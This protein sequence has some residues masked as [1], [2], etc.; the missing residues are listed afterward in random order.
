MR[1]LK[2]AAAAVNQT[3]LDWQG[4][5][6]RLLAAITEAQAQGVS[7]LVTPELGVTGYGCEDAFLGFDVATRAEAVIATL[8]PHTRGICVVVGAP[9]AIESGLYNGAWVL[10]DGHLVAIVAKE[11]LAGDGV[12]YEPRWF[13]PWP[14]RA[15]RDVVRAGQSCPFGDL[16]VSLDDIRVGFEICEDAWI[17]VRRGLDFAALDVDVIVNP[18]AS[19]FAFAKHTT[20][21]QIVREGSRS[22]RAVYI[23]ANLLGNEAGRIVYDGGSL[24]AARGELVAQAPRFSFKPYHLTVA[25]VDVAL[26]R[27]E[28][29]RVSTLEALCPTDAR[30]VQVAFRLPEAEPGAKTNPGTAAWEHAPHLK[31]EEFAR[32]VALGLYDY[33]RKSGTQGYVVSLSGGADSAAVALLA[34]LAQRLAATELGTATSL[35]AF[36]HRADAL[37]QELLMCVYQASANSS[38]ATRDA[39][40]TVATALGAAFHAWEIQPLVDSY[41]TLAAQV[42]GRPLRWPDDDLALQNIQARVRAPGVW[43]LANLRRALLLTTS[44]RSEAAVGYATMDG[45]TCGGLAPIAGVD[46]AYLKRWLR[47]MEQHGIEGIGPMPWLACI[48]QQAPTAELRPPSAHQSDEEDLMPY[49]LLD[50]LERHA[51]GD[52]RAPADCLALL[53]A[54]FVELSRATLA[55]YVRRFFSLWA[56]NQWKRE[57]YAPSF[58]LDDQNLD[59]RSWCRFPILSGGFAEELGHLGEGE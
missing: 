34:H 53:R 12:H 38:Q 14:R 19:H 3:P 6:T 35:D 41:T 24:I 4:N 55:L 2:V 43:C 49:E 16:V 36:G 48:N 31:H 27:R 32:A 15:R 50:R 1:W 40:Q 10:A 8:L 13:K 47:F 52:K 26:L 22:Q 9:V 5:Q 25:N 18:S 57:R 44:N 54:E 30:L 11:H 20:R 17:P 42:I 58:H 21:E 33:A 46:K 28:R 59:P 29:H 56:H 45:D 23:Y 7:L 39:A 37:P 51:I